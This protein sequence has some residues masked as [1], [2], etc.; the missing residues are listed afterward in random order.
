MGLLLCCCLPCCSPTVCGIM[1]LY[2][3]LIWLV[4]C[5]II[6]EKFTN[7][8]RRKGVCK[9][10]C[11]Y[12][13]KALSLCSANNLE[14][15][16]RN[17]KRGRVDVQKK[18]WLEGE[19]QW[20][21]EHSVAFNCW[22]RWEGQKVATSLGRCERIPPMSSTFGSWCKKW[23]EENCFS[24]LQEMLFIIQFALKRLIYILVYWIKHTCGLY[25]DD[26]VVP[27]KL[28][29]NLCCHRPLLVTTRSLLG[30]CN[31]VI[32]CCMREDI[33]R[34]HHVS[35]HLLKKPLLYVSQLCILPFCLSFGCWCGLHVLM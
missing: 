28:E 31:A 4:V 25:I 29:C 10:T 11:I 5:S 30:T 15:T 27:L 6:I 1:F 17:C 19:T 34:S 13:L 33:K 32:P 22:A 8:E 18:G 14:Y 24:R 12:F 9:H 16:Y 23:D 2:I 21:K 35:Q 7:R 3:I 26:G 20:E